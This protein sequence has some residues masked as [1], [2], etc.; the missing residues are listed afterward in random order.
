[1]N[2]SINYGSILL[3][4]IKDVKMAYDDYTLSLSNSLL[5]LLNGDYDGKHKT[6]TI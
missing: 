6:Y 2:P 3:L 5:S 1:M 4:K